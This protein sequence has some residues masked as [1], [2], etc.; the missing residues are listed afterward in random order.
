MASESGAT[1]TATEY[2]QGH[3]TNHTV[4][5]SGSTIHMDTVI[6]SW[7]LGAVAFGLL[8]LASRAVQKEGVPGKVQAFVELVYDFVDGQVKDMFS[9]DRRFITGVCFTVFVWILV[10]N[11]VKFVPVDFLG[12]FTHLFA[13]HWKPVATADLNTTLALSLSV[14]LLVIVLS[15]KAKSF[16]GYMHE[17]F[18][19][20]FHGPNIV[21]II[22]LAPFNFVFQMIE[23]I[24]KPLS[25]ALRLYGNMYAGEI[26]FLLISLL[27][28]AGIGG[29]FFGGLLHAGWAIFHILVVPLQAFIFMMLTAVYLAMAH[30][31]H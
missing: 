27:S 5:F 16:G 14:I 2:I 7:L 28:A 4:N 29:V 18:C 15:I 12:L 22:I 1:K 8:W 31:A 10:M 24:S 17:L 26:I 3:L 6:T 25:L 19:T 20:P 30:E 21:A 9:G 23:L 11:M 13:P